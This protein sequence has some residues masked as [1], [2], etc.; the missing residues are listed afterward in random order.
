MLILMIFIIVPCINIV[1]QI[2]IAAY[3]P[4]VARDSYW[5]SFL[6]F[7]MVA[8]TAK[9]VQFFLIVRTSFI[10]DAQAYI[11][12]RELVQDMNED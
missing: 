6:V 2:F 3:P 10:R 12:N 8:C 11:A 5:E 4:V 7:F 1:C 9:P